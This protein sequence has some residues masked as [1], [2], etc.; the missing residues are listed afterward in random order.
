MRDRVA[1]SEHVV[2]VDDRGCGVDR[3][4]RD[5]TAQQHAEPSVQA[6][7][8]EHVRAQAEAGDGDV[9]VVGLVQREEVGRRTQPLRQPHRDDAGV[10]D[11]RFRP[12][13][14]QRARVPL[15]RRGDPQR[16]GVAVQAQRGGVDD[17]ADVPEDRPPSGH[18]DRTGRAD[19]RAQVAVASGELPGQDGRARGP[20]VGAGVGRG[21]AQREPAA[22][23]R[24]AVAG[25]VDGVRDRHRRPVTGQGQVV[26]TVQQG[27]HREQARD[28]AAHDEDPSQ[29]RRSEATHAAAPTAPAMV[30]TAGQAPI[31]RAS[32][33]LPT[34]PPA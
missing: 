31:P 21:V 16:E 25:D 23:G 20:A 24:R 9:G 14:Q 28:P 4:V 19:V 18:D 15:G 17:V 10:G 34:N 12:A 27:L 11:Q 1:G 3:A 32:R 33:W 30:I 2:V 13:L 8:G 29:P 22:A 6:G 5:R 7:V 26:G